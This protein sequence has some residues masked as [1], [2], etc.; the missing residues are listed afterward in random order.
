MRLIEY[1]ESLIMA[2]LKRKWVRFWMRY[3]G[4]EGFGRLAT[5]LASLFALPHKA[6]IYLAYLNPVGYISPTATIHHSD[7]KLLGNVLIGDRVIIYQAKDGGCVEICKQV[8]ILRDTIL[9]TGFGG[10][11]RIGETTCIHPRCQLNAYV[12]PIE[13]GSGVDI[14]PN[15]SFYSYNHGFIGDRP[16]RE[17]PLIAKGKI[18]IDDDAWLGVGV[19]V[20]SGVH[21]GKG[22]VIGAG[23]IVTQNIPDGAVAVGRPAR[24]IKMRSDIH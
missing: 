15:C 3:A 13:I 6:S 2:K 19:T 22:A 8:C 10:Y 5:R 24:V 20:L 17:Q 21:I 23:S 11:I 7:L 9:E 18:R 12:E 4:I 16:I 14:A 1:Y